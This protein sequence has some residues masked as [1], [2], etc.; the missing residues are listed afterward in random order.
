MRVSSLVLLGACAPDPTGDPCRQGFARAADGH[1]Y[2]PLTEPEPADATGVLDAAPPC[3]PREPDGLVDLEAGC[4]GAVCAGDTYADVALEAG[5]GECTTAS[6]STQYRYCVFEPG[7]QALFADLDED[8]VPEDEST[9]DWVR[10][11]REYPHATAEGLGTDTSPRCWTG[12][13]GTPSDV[14]FVDVAGSLVLDAM[15][16]DRYGV[17]V[18]DWSGGDGLVDTAYLFGAP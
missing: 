3:V 8:G 2:P 13:L 9:T 11:L 14:R 1:C 16:W 17:E 4:A 7:V 10:L 18:H 12:A 6:W 5:P 15:I